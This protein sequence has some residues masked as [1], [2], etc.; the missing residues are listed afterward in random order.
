MIDPPPLNPPQL[1]NELARDVHA[2]GGRAL[3][4]GGVVRDHLLGRQVVDW[5]IE[6][7]ELPEDQLYRLIRRLGQVDT[8]GRA[9]AVFKLTRGALTIDISLPRTDSKA[10][11]GHKGIAVRGDPFLGVHEAS[12]R[13][14]LTVNAILYDLTEQTYIDPFHGLV[15]LNA[16]RLRAVDAETFLEDPLRALRVVQFAGRLGATPDAALLALCRQAPLHELPAERI[17]GEWFKLLLSDQPSVGLQVARDAQ[18]L[19]RVFPGAPTDVGKALDRAA[20]ERDQL[21]H[22]PRRLALMLTTWLYTATAHAVATTLD[23]LG[24]IRW[25]GYRLR[26]AV[27]RAH[28]TRHYPSDSDASLRHLATLCE[29]YLVLT[30]RLAHRMDPNAE[31]HRD[32]AGALGVLTDPEPP[33]VQGRDLLALGL[34]PGPRIGVVLGELYRDQLDRTH[35]SRDSAMA[36]AARIVD[37]GAS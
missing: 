31:R 34:K 2:A 6:V 4:V 29:P 12:R 7:H 23:T 30:A 11:P 21:A 8:V 20:T 3:A 16:R 10:G 36:A 1:V 9:F 17:V 35:E 33:W 22:V 25:D 19:S 32:R 27:V 14:D 13:R 18:I 24:I 15:D 26:E 5:D 37:E 28:A